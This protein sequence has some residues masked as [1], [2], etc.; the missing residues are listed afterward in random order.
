MANRFKV[1][2]ALIAAAAFVTLPAAPANAA[3]GTVCAW[4]VPAGWVK[5]NDQWDPTRCGNPTAIVNNVWTIETYYDKNIG[6]VMNVCRGWVPTGWTTISSRWD[7]TRCDHPTAIYD[8][9]Y[10]IRRLF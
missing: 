4:S 6:A 8:N 3:V 5:T 10:T 7:P 1:L 2:M 9:V